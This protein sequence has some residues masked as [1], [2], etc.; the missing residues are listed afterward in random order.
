MN[1]DSSFS[2]VMI[3]DTPLSVALVLKHKLPYFG[4]GPFVMTNV[5]HLVV[6]Y[7]P[8]GFEFGY[9]GKGP[10]DLALNICE[11]YLM[12][13]EYKGERT[14]CKKGDCF[15]LAFALHRDFV[16]DFIEKAPREGTTI[17]YAD[18]K[19]WFDDHI[20]AGLV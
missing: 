18:L 19:N 15:S 20:T 3:Q 13:I 12:Q 16:R 6:F 11:W 2:D 7:S 10:H 1:E 17:P 8:T 4:Y 9:D 5:P 14:E